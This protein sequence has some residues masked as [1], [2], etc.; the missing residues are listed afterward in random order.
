MILS[1]LFDTMIR[2]DELLRLDLKCAF[3]CSQWNLL[4]HH[5]PY[6]S[7]YSGSFSDCQNHCEKIPSAS[8]LKSFWQ[9]KIQSYSPDD[10]LIYYGLTILRFNVYQ[11][12]Y[13]GFL[14]VR[15]KT[16]IILV[17]ISISLPIQPMIS[18]ILIS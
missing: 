2:A 10:I 8:V 14:D 11:N 4:P 7:K 5:Y 17:P 15:C 13:L 3:F 16:N 18:S 1:T 12:F 9:D 6:K